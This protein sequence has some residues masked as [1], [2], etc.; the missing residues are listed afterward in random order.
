M[1]GASVQLGRIREDDE[2]VT[3]SYSVSGSEV[4]VSTA[5]VAVSTAPAVVPSHPYLLSMIPRV[6][7]KIRLTQREIP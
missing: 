1:P 3:V 2:E 6:D 5:A 7:K 4:A